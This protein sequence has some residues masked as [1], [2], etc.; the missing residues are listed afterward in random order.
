MNLDAIGIVSEDMS[1]SIEFYK[2]LDVHFKDIGAG[3][4]HLEATTSSGLRLMLD[5]S[6]LMKKLNP[7]W[8]SP[9][10]VGFIL[11]FKQNSVE[12]L[13]QLYK[14]VVESGFTGAKEPWD[15][16]WGQRYACIK[17]P[18][19]NQIDLFAGLPST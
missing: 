9:R 14:T 15:A 4:D 7:E 18:S 17:D 3:G 12:E 19:G 11:A 6:E 16:F 1:K 5:S 10:G 2:L 13:N 8:E